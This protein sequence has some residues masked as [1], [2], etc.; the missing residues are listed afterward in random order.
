MIKTHTAVMK[1]LNI[2]LFHVDRLEWTTCCTVTDSG[3]L[4]EVALS[5]LLLRESVRLG[6]QH[7]CDAAKRSSGDDQVSHSPSVYYSLTVTHKSF[8]KVPFPSGS[9]TLKA[10]RMVSSGS[11]PKNGQALFEMI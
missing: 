8:F 3:A 7:I 2:L 1:H 10:L 9:K 5:H 11:A 4:T 6:R